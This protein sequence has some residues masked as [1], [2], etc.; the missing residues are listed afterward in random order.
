[1]FLA[2][3]SGRPPTAVTS[4]AESDEAAWLDLQNPTDEERALAERLT[5]LRIP[6]RMDV[7]E[8]ESSSRV[9]MEGQTFYLSTPLVRRGDGLAFTSPLGFVL[10]ADRL[11]TIRYTD[12]PVFETISGR[13]AKNSDPHGSEDTM[14]MLLEGFI[15]RIADLLEGSGHDLDELSARIFRSVEPGD[16]TSHDRLLRELLQKIGKEAKLAS[17]IR[18]SLL[19]LQR[20]ILYISDSA[21]RPCHEHLAARLHLLSKDIGSLNDY[22]SQINNKVQFL[23]DATLGFINIEQNNGIKILT[24]V[25]IVGI[26]PTLI[27]SIYGMNFKD[28]PELSWSF[29]YWYALALMG[30]TIVAPLIWFW[31][32]GWLGGK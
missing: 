5:G 6:T 30:F 14:V 12:F 26:P 18:D 28:I 2:H 27:A 29:G 13:I 25:S 4:E 9:Y 21:E 10:S 11:V 24:V 23:L 20:I 7:E 8:I 19:G 3:P 1:M 15:D 17:A 31:R 32:K 22:D 16:G